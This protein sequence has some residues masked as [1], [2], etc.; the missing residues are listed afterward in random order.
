MI[1]RIVEDYIRLHSGSYNNTL[2]NMKLTAYLIV[3]N[4]TIYAINGYM[5]LNGII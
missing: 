3:A 5:L 2:R 1:D 4:I